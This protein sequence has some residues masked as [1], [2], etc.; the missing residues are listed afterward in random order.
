[1]AD[2]PNDDDHRPLS[3]LDAPTSTEGVSLEPL[4]V[5]KGFNSEE[6]RKLVLKDGDFC[7]FKL[8]S[9]EMAE[10]ADVMKIQEK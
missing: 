9:F 6:N 4:A 5:N 7:L 1:M 2:N 8:R 10:I 3:L